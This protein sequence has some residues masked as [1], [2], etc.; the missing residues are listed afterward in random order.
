MCVSCKRI[1]CVEKSKVK[2]YYASAGKILIDDLHIN[3]QEWRD[4]GGN[5]ILHVNAES[6]IKALTS[7]R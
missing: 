2:K 5:G 7:I 3:I 4:W 6:T 1:I